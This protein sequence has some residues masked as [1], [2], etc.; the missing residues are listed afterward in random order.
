MDEA[1]RC[2]HIAFMDAGR[3]TRTGTPDEL[4]AAVPG[5]LLEVAA[6]DPRAALAAVQ[7]LPGVVSVHLL[8]DVV[9]VLMEQEG[10][11]PP[12]PGR[13]GGGAAVLDAALARAGVD[14]A[15]RE[16]RMDM[17]SVFSYFAEEVRP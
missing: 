14:A 7:G 5:T 4:K 10:Q 2:S 15:A 8:G 9:R 1:E 13:A 16:I 3:I 11:P 17:E 12:V 6:T